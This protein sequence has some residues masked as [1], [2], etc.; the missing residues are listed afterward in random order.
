MWSVCRYSG[1]GRRRRRARRHSRLQHAAH[2]HALRA[3]V[4]TNDDAHRVRKCADTI[5]TVPV[6][7]AGHLQC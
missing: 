4:M 3:P 2:R 1:G 5:G 7:W 6:L